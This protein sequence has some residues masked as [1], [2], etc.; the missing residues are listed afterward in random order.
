MGARGRSN[1]PMLGRVGLE[2]MTWVTAFP[3]AGNITVNSTIS[4][5][6]SLP[7]EPASG[8]KTPPIWLLGWASGGIKNRGRRD[9][10]QALPE[11][12]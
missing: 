3:C 10:V 6:G 12:P 5:G 8:H 1:V 11:A 9:S 2:A 4:D 7:T